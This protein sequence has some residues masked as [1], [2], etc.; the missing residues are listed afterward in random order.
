[1]GK[2]KEK[3]KIICLYCKKEFEVIPYYSNKIFCSISCSNTSK[4][5][6]TNKDNN[7]GRHHTEEHKE[8]MSNKMMGRIFSDETIEKMT[9]NHWANGDKREATIISFKKNY[10]GNHE[11]AENAKNNMSNSRLDLISENLGNF[12]GLKGYYISK[13]TGNREI[14]DSL[15]EFKRMLDFDFDDDVLFWTKKHKL[16]LGYEY[17]NK[18]CNFLPDFFIEY[19]NKKVFEEVKSSY[20]EKIFVEKNNKKKEI[21]NDYCSKNNFIFFWNIVEIDYQERKKLLKNLDDLQ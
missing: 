19:K 20:T 11:V 3:V 15:Y 9:K 14:Y 6:T 21:L 5:K 2:K 18:K 7:V 16:K 13:K 4:N 12:F 17:N 8:Y 1:M 10:W